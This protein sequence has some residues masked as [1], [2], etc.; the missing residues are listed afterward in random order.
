MNHSLHD[1]HGEL[2][3]VSQFTLLAN[4]AKERRPGFEEAAPPEEARRYYQKVLE[5]FGSSDFS[6]GDSQFSDPFSK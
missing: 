6:V 2:L 1:I 3:L 5:Q 4:T